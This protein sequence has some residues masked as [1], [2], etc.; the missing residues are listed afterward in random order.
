MERMARRGVLV[1]V[2]A[3]LALWPA[4]AGAH[5]EKT[6]TKPDQGQKLQRAPSRVSVNLTE[7][8]TADARF[9]VRD[10]CGRNVAEAPSVE[11][12]VLGAAIDGGEP[13]TWRVEYRIVSTVDGHPTSDGWSFAVQGKKDCSQPEPEPTDGGAAPDN[14]AAGGPTGGGDGDDDGSSFP[15]VP[16]AAGTVVLV[17]VALLIRGR[18]TE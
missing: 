12:Q 6:T 8:P 15:V 18:S 16:V 3:V 11:G 7:P 2:A 9:V 17:A 10:G 1:A 5:G 4:I 13:G 14:G